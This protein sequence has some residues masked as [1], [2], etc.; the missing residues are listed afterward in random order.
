MLS[1]SRRSG[2]RVFLNVNGVWLSVAISTVDRGKVVL[3]FGVPRSLRVVREE[4][5][6]AT[7][8]RE[9]EASK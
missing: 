8:R 4:I 1:L 7:D 9:A 2:E 6:S 3:A 5:M